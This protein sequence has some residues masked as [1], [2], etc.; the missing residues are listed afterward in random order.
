VHCI[1]KNDLDFTSVDGSNKKAR[2]YQET[3][4][5]FI[6]ETDFNAI[7]GDQMRLGKT[8]QSLLAL[9]NRF[10]ERT[11]C[12]ILVRSANLWQWIR[13]FKTW[14]SVLP[15]GIYPIIGSK[16]WI[17]PGFRCYIISM[18]TFSRPAVLEQLKQIPFKL[19]IADEAH[20]FKNT[21][22]NRSQT[23]TDFITFLNTGEEIRE[24]K[25]TCSRCNHE[26][27]ELGK[28]KYDKR[29]GNT[30]ISKSTRCPRCDNYCYVNQQHKQT[31]GGVEPKLVPQIDKL[32]ALGND[33]STTEHERQLAL[34][35]ALELAE[36]NK[37][38]VSK[39]CGLVLLSGTILK[40]RAEETFVPLNLCDPEKFNSLDRYRQEW[41]TQDLKG[42]WS[43]IK[44]YRLEEWKR[45]VA[46]IML[47]REWTDVYSDIPKL[48][49]TFTV[50]E[51]EKGHLTAA[52]NVILDK[53]DL[54][55]AKK[56][57]PSYWDMAEDLMELR[58][59]CGLMKVMYV[60]DYLQELLEQNGG[61]RYAVGLHHEAV[62]D[63]LFQKLDGSANCLKLDGSST[64]SSSD[65]DY[66][67][68]SFET[69]EQKIL[70]IGMLA[71]GIGMDFHYVNNVLILERQWSAADEEQFEARFFNPDKSIKTAP[72]NVEYILVKGSIEAFFY[73]M[74][75]TKRRI[76]GQTLGSKWS[77]TQDTASFSDL[78][79]QATSTRL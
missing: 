39:P 35:K 79:R 13:E 29:I 20:S 7:I 41:L 43:N 26:W 9:K 15:N 70:L 48:N 76:F 5:Q 10:A 56:C 61:Q 77:V 45:N 2:I 6:L 22:S 49:R 11:P 58:R 62:R 4:V 31:D 66:V 44:S 18:D 52:Y 46:P 69:S 21:D 75:E 68:R 40:N 34:S 47:R 28:R 64:P 25:F 37:V 12:L 42:K 57:V 19:V 1:D 8:P 38:P 60:G 16:A 50:I 24:L 51:A 71:G 73:E 74:V 23:L 32:L 27:A 63:V 14:T 30:V 55:L 36:K 54:K 65:K 59:I 53:M 3:G 33:K 67:M 78:I 17:P 72:T